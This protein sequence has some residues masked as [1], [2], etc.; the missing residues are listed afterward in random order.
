MIVLRVYPI[1]FILKQDQYQ[2]TDQLFDRL[3]GA[4]INVLELQLFKSK[5]NLLSP[6]FFLTF[7]SCA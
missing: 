1:N 6:F 7:S 5:A 2:T 3:E 4:A